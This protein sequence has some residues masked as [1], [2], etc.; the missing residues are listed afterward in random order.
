MTDP[1]APLIPFDVC[2]AL[3]GMGMGMGKGKEKRRRGKFIIMGIPLVG[4]SFGKRKDSNI[5]VE[6]TTHQNPTFWTK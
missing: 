1:S 4:K 2:L 6:D 5:L 3:F